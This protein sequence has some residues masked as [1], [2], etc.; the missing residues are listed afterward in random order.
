ML[1]MDLEFSTN[2]NCSGLAS[3]IPKSTSL[4]FNSTG[5]II[6]NNVNQE[7]YR[8]LKEDNMRLQHEIFELK[9][10]LSNSRRIIE[11]L[12]LKILKNDSFNS[13]S[14]T[15][16]LAKLNKEKKDFMDQIQDNFRKAQT[17][18]KSDLTTKLDSE[19]KEKLEVKKKY[20]EA[21][22]ELN[23]TKR[24]IKIQ[25]KKIKRLENDL[26]MFTDTQNRSF[27]ILKMLEAFE[28]FNEEL[29]D[30]NE[31]FFGRDLQNYSIDQIKELT[32]TLC[33]V[34]LVKSKEL[35]AYKM[36]EAE[37]N[38]IIEEKLVEEQ[39]KN[40]NLVDLLDKSSETLNKIRI[41]LQEKVQYIGL[42]EDVLESQNAKL[43]YFEDICNSSTERM[44]KELISEF[45]DCINMIKSLSLN[46]SE[47]V[48][49]KFVQTDLMSASQDNLEKNEIEDEMQPMFNSNYLEKKIRQIKKLKHNLYILQLEYNSCQL[50][51][52]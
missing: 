11:D 24:S 40:I 25:N 43:N 41:E 50:F 15:T 26:N 22:N 13:L 28:N 48:K 29:K 42:I 20:D 1:E 21:L 31:K 44:F 46:I 19:T 16:E 32:E 47:G 39:K 9:A 7:D 45:N 14:Y 38:K 49:H 23:S 27:K 10:D 30:L 6:S 51:D 3:G 33:G 17:F 4:T 37:K 12:N 8:R 2:Y 35:N 36:N 5:V 52:I 18:Y 34:I